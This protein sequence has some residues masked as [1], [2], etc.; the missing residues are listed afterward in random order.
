MFTV[1]VLF[2]LSGWNPHV[3]V[4]STHV[5]RKLHASVVDS[6]NL[7]YIIFLYYRHFVHFVYITQLLRLMNIIG[8]IQPAKKINKE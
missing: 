3:L 6:Y 4:D 1:S 7:Q 5:F 2:P 8:N